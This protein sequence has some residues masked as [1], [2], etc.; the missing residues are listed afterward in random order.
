MVLTACRRVSSAE[1][2]V[3]FLESHKTVSPQISILLTGLAGPRPH[4][5]CVLIPQ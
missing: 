1:Q 5:S 2:L 4:V 3:P